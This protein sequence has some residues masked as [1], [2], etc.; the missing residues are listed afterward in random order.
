MLRLAAFLLLALFVDSVARADLLPPGTQNVAV[1]H[2]FECD[3]AHTDWT[4]YRVLGRGGVE[5][6]SI[7]PGSTY[8]IVGSSAIG[9][10]PVL[11]PGEKPRP[12]SYRASLLV[13]VPSGSASQFKSDKE[14]HEAID[15]LSVPGLIRTKD[16]FHDHINV[17]A[18][19]AR[20][21]IRKFYRVVSVDSKDG[22]VLQ[23][24]K[25]SKGVPKDDR[26]GVPVPQEEDL[27]NPK[28]PWTSIGFCVAGVALLIG[29]I[30]SRR[31]NTAKGT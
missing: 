4:F 21:K 7:R 25:G 9:R 5:I 10:G 28:I 15:D 2:F 13:A 6:A 19:D 26:D 17:K 23:S 29:F 8:S 27:I 30:A 24:V 11:Q 22:I 16:E 1:D 20:R 12:V 31:G 18:D 14:Y 3:Q